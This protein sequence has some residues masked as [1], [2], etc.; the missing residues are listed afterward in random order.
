MLRA[1]L[2]VLAVLLALP[3]TAHADPGMQLGIS[4]DR[5]L[6][7]GGPPADAAVAEWQRLGVDT[8]R[9]FANWGRIAPAPEATREPSGFVAADPASPGY[10]WTALDAA[11]G[12]VR[13]AGLDVILNVTGPGPVWASG[14]PSLHNPRYEPSPTAYA[15][16]ATAAARRYGAQVGTYVLWNEPNQPSWLQPQ[17]HCVRGRCTP[18]APHVYRAL[19]RAAYPA[20]RAADPGARILIGALAPRGSSATSTNAQLRPLAFVRALGCVDAR[21]RPIRTGACHG[22]RAATADGFA[23]HPHGVLNS[24]HTPFLN[25]DDVDLASLPRLESTLDR[26]QARGALRPTTAHF[27]LYLDEFG[28]QTDPPDRLLGVSLATQDSWLQESAYRAW[29]DPR[30]HLLVQ[31]EWRDEPASADSSYS[32]WQSGLRYADGRPKPALAHFAMPLYLDA[33][34]GR[35]WGQVRPGGAHTV[36]VQR[37]LRGRSAWTDVATVRTDATGAWTKATRF[38]A[39][40]AYRFLADGETSGVRVR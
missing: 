2:L 7:G 11:I 22:F 5:V 3:A 13:A 6:L 17:S 38:V 12:R 14:R 35:L 24:P 28:Y 21:F 29:A 16:F 33:A 15:A 8:V 4:D 36:T 25:A 10:D 18:V 37:R 40:A 27:G 19:V 1:R 26:L 32:G 30:V 34:R 31:Y 23:Y 20:I 39:G 9:I